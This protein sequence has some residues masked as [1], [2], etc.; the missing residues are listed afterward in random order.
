MTG[1][2]SAPETVLGSGQREISF[3]LSSMEERA[4]MSD[5]DLTIV[6]QP[7]SENIH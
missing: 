4:R 6:S 2:G 5:G 7:G 1:R 3:G